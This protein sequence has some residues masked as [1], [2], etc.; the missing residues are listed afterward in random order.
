MPTMTTWLWYLIPG[1]I[2]LRGLHRGYSVLSGGAIEG[3]PS[4]VRLIIAGL[5][6]LVG[7][8]A[9]GAQFGWF[10]GFR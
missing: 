8:L 7:G 6:I 5:Q 2:L 1:L 10:S 3:W 4:I 9:L